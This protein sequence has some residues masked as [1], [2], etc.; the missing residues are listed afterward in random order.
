MR[1]F[2]IGKQP[3]KVGF[4][5]LGSMGLFKVIVNISSTTPTDTLLSYR[6]DTLGG[7]LSEYTE[8]AINFDYITCMPA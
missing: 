5:G 2:V 7:A 1:G 8:T 4:I 6:P 3:R